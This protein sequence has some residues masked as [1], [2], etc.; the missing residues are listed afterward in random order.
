MRIALDAMGGDFAPREIVLGGLQAAEAR[1]EDEVLLVGNRAAVEAEIESAPGPVPPNLTVVHATQTIGMDEKPVEAV[2]RKPDSSILRA[3]KMVASGE[4]EAV[5]SAG[6]TGAVVA[7]AMLCLRPLRGVRRPGIA[8]SVPTATDGHCTLIDVG[9]NLNCKPIHLCQYAVMASIY[10][11]ALFHCERPRVGL[12]NVGEEESKGSPLIREA[13]SLLQRAPVEFTGN[14]EGRDIF[15]GN[16]E[17]VVC[18]GFVG[19]A[20]LKAAEGF[21]E[22]LADILRSAIFRDVWGRLSFNLMRPVL[23][24]L[25]RR[26]DFA[27]Y[28]GGPLLGVEGGVIICHGRSNAQAVRNAIFKAIT[29]IRSDVNGSISAALETGAEALATGGDRPGPDQAPKTT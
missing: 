11:A 24:N 19:N 28:G 2:K 12:L 5:V 29:F 6:N 10:H 3:V 7:A 16:H 23:L 15:G 27:H 18:D 22:T 17:V 21:G 20:I 14:A 4:A 26:V 25:Q 9:A 13:A 1:S 8:V